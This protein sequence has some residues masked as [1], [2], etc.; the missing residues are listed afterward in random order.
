MVRPPARRL[1]SLRLCVWAGVGV[2]GVDDGMIGR[3]GNRD[4][5][6]FSFGHNAV[7][8]VQCGG[9]RAVSSGGLH[10]C[11]LLGASSEKVAAVVVLAWLLV[12][13]V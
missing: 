6:L 12:V 7:A 10:A 8:G 13:L 11:F 5:I 2:V 9:W 3:W 4:V 1:L